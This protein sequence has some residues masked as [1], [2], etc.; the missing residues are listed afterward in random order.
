MYIPSFLLFLHRKENKNK[1]K[2]LLQ[3]VF[4]IVT[5]LT[6]NIVDA[7]HRFIRTSD[8]DYNVLVFI[9]VC[10]CVSGIEVSCA[11]APS[12]RWDIE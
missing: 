6:D 3:R 11:G 2:K 12:E 9:C 8:I 1:K 7:L 4:S 10:V 5:Y